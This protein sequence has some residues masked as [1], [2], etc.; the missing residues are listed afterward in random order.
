MRLFPALALLDRALDGRERLAAARHFGAIALARSAEHAGAPF[1]DGG[2]TEF[3]T[4]DDGVPQPLDGWS[5]SLTHT[6]GLV[7]GAVA[8][9]PVGVDA[10]WLGRRRWHHAREYFEDS[11]AEEL[12]LIGDDNL[13]VLSLWTA[14][15]AVLKRARVGLYDLARCPLVERTDEHAFLL[16]H[17]REEVHVVRRIFGEHVLALAYGEPFEL[18]LTTLPELVA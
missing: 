8:P 18:D 15:E 3:P 10:E 7:C 2:P 9:G 16:R 17:R 11:A 5:W 14:K 12:A 4:D 13:G 6:R 1:G